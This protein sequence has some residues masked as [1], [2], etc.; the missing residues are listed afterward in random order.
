MARPINKIATGPIKIPSR[1]CL[2]GNAK[3][4]PIGM[5]DAIMMIDERSPCC[6]DQLR[7]LNGRTNIPDPMAIRVTLI[8]SSFSPK[9]GFPINSP[10]RRFNFAARFRATDDP[11]S[12]QRAGDR[13][14]P[15]KCRSS[16]MSLVVG[17]RL[18]A[19]SK[20]LI[21]SV[22]PANAHPM[23]WPA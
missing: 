5:P 15:P 10:R 16:T 19:G 3:P 22:V 23:R 1:V 9:R 4:A 7:K 17:D 18:N 14:W 20:D 12:G 13:E 8:K 2:N 21:A 6:N 11:Q